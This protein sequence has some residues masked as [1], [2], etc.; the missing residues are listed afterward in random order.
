MKTIRV[1]RR[2]FAA[3]RSISQAIMD[4][5]PGS[6]IE[7]EQGVYRED[8]YIDKYIEIV[9]V[10]ERE[11]TII[12]GIERPTVQMAT[13]YAVIKNLTIK[14]PRKRNMDTV[15]IPDGALIL[16]DCDVV[17]RSGAGIVLM[18][19][20]AEPILRRCSIYSERNAAL[21]IQK[22]GKAI[23]EDCQLRT[24]NY[25]ALI[26]REGNPTIR[27]CTITG[28]EGYGIFIE[29][30]GRGYFEECNIF[31]FDYSPAIGILRGNPH[32]VRCRIHDGR[33]S[34]VV[35]E[36]GRGRF[37]DC[38][39]FSFEKD[40]P[41]VR[42]SKSAQPRFERCLFRS[43]KGGAFVFE[44]NAS[45]LIE[46][47]EC[48]GF[49]DA[50][51]VTIR[52]EAHPQL[53][54]CRIHDGNREGVICL[55]GG[56]GL[57]ESCEIYSFNGNNI[58]VLAGSQLDIL[59]CKIEKGK[60]HAI[61]IAQRSKGI[62]QDTQ[63]DHFPNLAAIHVAQAADPKVIQCTCSNSV[64][65]VRVTENGRGTFEHC[66]F[67]DIK[68]DVWKIEQG[69][70]QIY[71]CQEEGKEGS[72]KQDGTLSSVPVKLSEPLQ[73]LLSQLDRILG[74]Q[75]VKQSLRELILYLDYLQ[76]RK[77]MGIKTTE[78]PD[79][80]A[81]F[82]GPKH[83]GKLEV[84]T[85]YSKFLKELGYVGKSDFT[86]LSV[87][88]ELFING[89][90]EQTIWEEKMQQATEG[91]IYL[92][93]FP[94]LEE[95]QLMDEQLSFLRSFL[96]T[97]K[98]LGSVV[99]ILSVSEKQ[100]KEWLKRVP[101]FAELRQYQF[102]DYDPEEML[103][104]FYR[105]A[106]QEEY[107]VHVLARDPL[108]KEMVHLW[109]QEQKQGNYERVLAYFQQVKEVHS[110]RCSKL[111]KQQRSREVLTTIMPEDLQV[112]EKYIRPDH[113]DWI[114]YLEHNQK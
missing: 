95:S 34:G 2:F 42:L 17:A 30:R 40:L 41:A 61:F 9:G 114:K 70:P 107:Q 72:E 57:L 77:K 60:R 10:G 29:D 59:R 19:D 80:H 13:G 18:G 110:M 54:R 79:L 91:V 94:E 63:M 25:A 106:E 48:F 104:L 6:R 111:P 97:S 11:K 1:S 65:A 73:A 90:I 49:T 53:L 75:Q 108:I 113:K 31:G 39:F 102:Q 92:Y 71:L 101:V 51:A 20:E 64:H 35:I 26:V 99:G 69:N 93:H 86:P 103:Q 105:L 74:Q 5:E 87:Q 81:V 96:D 52:S 84:A 66:V 24:G 33:D 23:L 37:Q 44:E 8:L 4:A 82:V 78:Q 47:C 67:R 55:D 7:V 21:E 62:I 83:T 58:A 85:L 56:R 22:K 3:Y 43:C 100:W 89:K 109:E 38:K 45:G 112:S 16:D 68:E 14:H 50:P 32:F 28:D 76:D 12:Q 88:D 98:N 15:F 36:E 46:D 27:R